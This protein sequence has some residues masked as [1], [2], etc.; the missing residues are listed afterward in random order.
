[1]LKEKNIHID[2]K[3]KARDLSNEEWLALVRVFQEWPFKPEVRM[4]FLSFLSAIFCENLGF[5]FHL[6][7]R[8]FPHFPLKERLQTCEMCPRE[9]RLSII[10]ANKP[11]VSFLSLSLQIKNRTWS[12]MI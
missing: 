5:P 7:S 11:F 3:K 8:N 12:K 1:M 2:P 10:D 9:K 6:I 4:L